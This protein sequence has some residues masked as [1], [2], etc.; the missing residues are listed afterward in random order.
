MKYLPKLHNFWTYIL[1]LGSISKI[2][3]KIPQIFLYPN[4]EKASLE[5]KYFGIIGC[6]KRSDFWAFPHQIV[7]RQA[8]R[9]A[10]SQTAM[11]SEMG[12]KRADVIT[13]V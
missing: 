1:K 11:E 9:Q 6:I 3:N 2:L 8:R 7:N 5:L 13:P 10:I 4:L 12:Q